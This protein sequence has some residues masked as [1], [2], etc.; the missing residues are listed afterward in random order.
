MET[1]TA[2]PLPETLVEAIRQF[3]DPDVALAFAASA[4]WPTGPECPNCG[5]CD[6][7]FLKTR[8]LW[9]CRECKKQFSVKVG[10]IFEDSPIPLDKWMTAV[11][12]LVNAKNGISSYEVGRAIGVSQGCAWYMGHRIRLALQDHPT[13]KLGGHVEVDETF[14][15]GKARFMHKD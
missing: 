11:W 10:T 5:P 7:I 9:K 14:I 8:R 15:G 4:K 1:K 13:I 2:G 6:P 12:L 3:A